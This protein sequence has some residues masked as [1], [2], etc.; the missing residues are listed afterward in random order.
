MRE[1]IAAVAQS[2]LVESFIARWHEHEH[3]YFLRGY[4]ATP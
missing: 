1:T 3:K 2:Y 4:I